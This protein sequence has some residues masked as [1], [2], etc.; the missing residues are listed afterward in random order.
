MN[1]SIVAMFEM[2]IPEPFANPSTRRRSN[3]IFKRIGCHYRRKSAVSLGSNPGMAPQI[4]GR[5]R[6]ADD[7]G[8][9]EYSE[10]EHPMCLA[11]P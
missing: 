2:I 10:G 3:A 7:S 5:K 11:P 9:Y 8:R 4:V 1:E 6:P